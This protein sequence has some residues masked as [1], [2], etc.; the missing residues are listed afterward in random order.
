MTQNN[1]RIIISS[2]ILLMVDTFLSKQQKTYGSVIKLR[3]LLLPIAK[4]GNKQLVDSANSIWEDMVNKY[5][6]KGYIIIIA[7]AIEFLT[8]ELDLFTNNEL[9]TITR[10]IEKL[11]SPIDRDTLL[12]SREVVDYLIDRVDRL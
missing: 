2:Y 1:K 3:Q 7:D 5:S 9:I 12:K 6:G 8:F 4:S 10:A 11:Y